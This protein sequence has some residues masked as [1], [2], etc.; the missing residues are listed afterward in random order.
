MG[1]MRRR[2]RGPLRLLIAVGMLGSLLAVAL[3]VRAT[4]ATVVAIPT[5][6]TSGVPRYEA[7]PCVYELSPGL[8]EGEQIVCGYVIVAEKHAD[9]GGKTI[10]LPVAVIK[11]ISP[12]PAAEPIVLLAGG[13]GQSGQTFA[14]ISDPVLPFYGAVAAKNDVIFFDQR[15]TGKAE[16]SLQCPELLEGSRYRLK[17]PLLRAF[18]AESD[19]VAQMNACRERLVGRGI[20]LSA[21]TTSENAA[22]VNDVRIALGYGKIN[23]IGAS[24]GSELGLAVGR[25]W[26]QFVRTNNLVSL[27]PM[28][29]PWYFEPPQSF[30][31]AVKALATDCA[32]NVACNAANPNLLANF[33][34]VA[35]ALNVTPVILTLRD[36]QSGR[37]L[38]QLPLTGDDFVN[39]MFQLFYVTQFVPFFPD[40]ITRAASGNFV[41]LESLLPLI[42]GDGSDGLALG[43]HFSVVCSKDPSQAKLNAALAANAT[44]LPEIRRALEPG[45]RDYYEICTNWPSKDADPQGATPASFDLPTT[46]VSGQFD[47]ITPPKYATSAAETLPN[48]TSVTLQGGGHSAITPFERV[49]ECGLTIMLSLI[50]SGTTADTSC[51]AALQ[52]TYRA[53]PPSIAGDPAPSAAPSATP[54]PTATRVPTAPPST[55]PSPPPTGNGGNLPGLPNTGAG[56]VV[57]VPATERSGDAPL[58]LLWWL[59]VPV[60]PVVPLVLVGIRLRRRY[61]RA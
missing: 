8:V 13:P 4:A 16:P 55:I 19:F 56:S 34:R 39:V 45:T 27:V 31:L 15:G 26:G 28:Q 5:P 60:V 57:A 32:A 40:M 2:W 23:I 61:V 14:S 47:P 49:G 1:A 46:L 44:I 30:D 25:D 18:S 9:P 42:L 21:Y 53:L 29:T 50:A 10:K 24:Y 3:P 58:H 52:T 22:D 38:A 35:N 37:V 51:A 12:T 33:Q 11:A 48:A 41:W 43:M 7:G 36:P 6:V 20:D 59:L 17:E 54:V